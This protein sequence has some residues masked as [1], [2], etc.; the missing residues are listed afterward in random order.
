MDLGSATLFDLTPAGVGADEP[1]TPEPE[2]VVSPDAKLLAEIYE[3]GVLIAYREVARIRRIAHWARTHVVEKP[4]DAA[5]ITD[6]ALDTGMPIAGE[7][8]PLISGHAVVEISAVLGRS[9]DSGRHLVGQVVELDH[10]LPRT[11]TGLLEGRVPVWKGL[12][13]ADLTRPLNPE[14]AGFVDQQLSE[15]AAT[16]S[17]AQIDRLIDEALVRYEPDEAERRRQAA[18]EHRHFT[19]DLDQSGI[20]GLVDLTGVLDLADAL[21]LNAAITRRA[22]HLADLGSD[23][24][25]DVRRAKAAG[26]LA[27]ADHA[28]DLQPG[29]PTT[30][31]PAVDLP[32]AGVSSPGRAAPGRKIELFV[33]LTAAALEGG[34]PVGR[35]ENTDTPITLGQI[36]EWC[37]NPDAKITI[38]PVIDLNGC[39]PVNAYEIPDRIRTQVTLRDLKCAFPNCTKRAHRCDI[40]HRI[41]H[42]DGGPTCACNLVPACRS[43]HRAKTHAGWTYLI[44]TPGHYLWCSPHGQLWIVDPHGT[45]ILDRR[46][47]K[48]TTRHQHRPPDE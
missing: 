25:L 9:L 34:N 35:L 45:H 5:T 29:E 43:H 30:G 18:A 42:A 38:R 8:A 3:D 44:L 39:R 7:G 1:T 31:R 16:C 36:R 24:S 23:D 2:R 22:T 4:E 41:P 20:D 47:F 40:D 19:L 26:E 6:Y 37:A 12:R 33:H 15:F 27:R 21:D 46:T 13:I 11:W 32:A 17:W 48:S 28:L 10:R 14:A